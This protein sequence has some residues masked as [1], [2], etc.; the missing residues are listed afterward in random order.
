MW[1]YS[2]CKLYTEGI[3]WCD[4]PSSSNQNHQSHY[5]KHTNGQED[6]VLSP[7]FQDTNSTERSKFF[8]RLGFFVKLMLKISKG[9]GS[10]K[11]QT[12]DPTVSSCS[13]TYQC[14][15]K[16]SSAHKASLV[17]QTVK[18]LHAMWPI[19]VWSLGQEDPLEKEMAT[20]SS[21]ENSKDWL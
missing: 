8:Q 21:L 12:A 4:I 13:L 17:A 5:G 10:Q 19:Q 15:S 9:P 18:N 1:K 6:Y 2:G 20:H 11:Q 16:G 7:D 3:I 14:Y